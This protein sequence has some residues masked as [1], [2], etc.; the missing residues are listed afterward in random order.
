MQAIVA[1][2]RTPGYPAEIVAVISNRPEAGGLAWA[3]GQ[4]IAAHSIDHK[5]YPS[6]E[7]FEADLQASLV[8]CGAEIVVLA[9][10]MRL[11]T[12]PFVEAWRGRM[13]NIHPS[14]LPA[15][16]GLDTHA[17]AIEAG[18]TLAGCTVHFVT[19]DMDGG[20]IIVQ[21]A[22]P[23]THDDTPDT[24]AARIIT[25]EHKIYP[26]ALAWVARGEVTFEEPRRRATAEAADI[27]IWPPTG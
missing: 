16:K 5:G 11:M 20:P 8:G 25:A 19:P 23:V 4:G 6:R 26:Q 3:R 15:F 12:A 21:A 13:I 17:R 24:L 9:G 27:L 7:A 1:A 18:A 2:S 22:V 10:F 14:L